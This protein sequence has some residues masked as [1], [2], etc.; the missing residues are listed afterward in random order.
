ML[1]P[2]HIGSVG[3][4]HVLL[5]VISVRDRAVG[6]VLALGG[7]VALCAMM[8]PLRHHLSVATPA[9]V[10]VVP[11]VG[12]VAIGGFAIGLVAAVV[13]FLAYDF[14]FIPPFGTLDVGAGQ[15]WTA[16]GV[17]FVVVLVGARLVS[18]LQEA[19][20]R[21]TRQE[22]ATRRMYDLTDRLIAERPL[23]ELLR[24]VA[25]S[26]QLSL[27]ARWVV[28]LVAGGARPEDPLVVAAEAGTPLS[29]QER[30]ILLPEAGHVQSL[31]SGAGQPLRDLGR[32]ADPPDVLRVAL[33][34]AQRPVGM[35]VLAG[36]EL[37]RHNQ[38][39]LGAFA[40]QAAQAVERSILREQ[41]LR[42]DVLEESDRWRRALMSA[43]SHD[44]RTP[45]ATI[46]TAV[47]TLRDRSVRLG[48]DAQGEL[49]TL[50]EEQ[51]DGL[52]RLVTD[53]LDLSRLESG[54]LVL[55]RR[56]NVLE[57]M[58]G[59]A[60]SIL[61]S[62]ADVRLRVPP[63]LPPVDV[64]EVL[65]TQVL[66]NLI[67]NARRHTPPG[68][69]VDI[70]AVCSGDVVELAVSD[71]GPGVP[72]EDRQRVFEMFAR[73]SSGGRAG[74]GLAIAK[75]F[76]DAHGQHIEMQEAPGGGARVVVRMAVADDGIA[77]QGLAAGHPSVP[78]GR[79]TGTTGQP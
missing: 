43:V 41:A 70:E 73:G 19:R 74:L 46:K 66:V 40:H 72:P 24:V 33:V 79:T 76:V 44:L 59:S 6:M 31:M 63:A 37:D 30:A 62:G 14:F 48:P 51:A 21:A 10:L 29:D 53:L 28:A 67:E 39:L 52:A 36:T 3:K 22:E 50:V 27:G 4:P 25:E 57:D 13:G 60:I 18:F 65:M 58:V 71:H 38:E 26:V 20:A 68:T 78:M 47:S 35:L 77:D 17:Y 34:T 23:P 49:L 32:S 5:P 1:L 9:L 55:Q 64:D 16:L 54:G 45:L 42:A 11:V 61:Q 8:I 56:P 2:A 75:A 12:A 69:T 7:T 15:N